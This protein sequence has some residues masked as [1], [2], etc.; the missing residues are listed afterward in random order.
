VSDINPTVVRVAAAI[1]RSFEMNAGPGTSVQAHPNQ[2]FVNLNGAVD[3]YKAAEMVQA[4]YD[5]EIDALRS[6]LAKLKAAA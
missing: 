2:F 1:R 5:Q 3:L 6:E 4:I